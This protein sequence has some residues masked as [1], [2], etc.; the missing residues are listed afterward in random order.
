MNRNCYRLVFNTT[1]GMMVPVAETARRSGKARLG[2][3]CERCGAGAGRRVAGGAGSCG[4]AGGE[5]EFCRAR[6]HGELSGER[7]AGLRR[8]RSATRRSSI[9]IAST[10][11]P[12]MTCSS[13]RWTA[14]RRRIWC[15]VRVS[16]RSPAFTTSIPASLPAA[17]S[18]A[19]GQKANVT[20]INSN[21]IAFMGGVAG[22]PQQFHGEHAEHC[23]QLHRQFPA[24]A[25]TA[26]RSSRMRW[27]GGEG[28]ASSRCSKARRSPRAARAG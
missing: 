24:D 16:R 14:W 12:G 9:S 15:R 17:C 25:T 22:E 27:I 8:T 11:A 10:S 23:G 20:L 21:G 13:A 4:I 18:Q 6:H 19:A 7:R 3:G 26:R 5:R 1:L 2:H 28:A